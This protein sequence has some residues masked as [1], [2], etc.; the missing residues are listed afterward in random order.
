MRRRQDGTQRPYLFLVGEGEMRASEGLT[1]SQLVK[2]AENMITLKAE[3]DGLLSESTGDKQRYKIAP[4]AS[5][6]N[7][8]I[9]KML[10]IQ[11][12]RTQVIPLHLAAKE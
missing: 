12:D 3:S 2:F 1:F 7:G 10:K 6:K 11:P 9:V 5:L 4:L 8:P